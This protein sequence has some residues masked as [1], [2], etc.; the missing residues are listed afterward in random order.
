MASNRSLA[1]FNLSKQPELEE[2]KQVLRELSEQASQLCSSVRDKIN[3]MR[4]LSYIINNFNRKELFF[5]AVYT[6]IGDKSGTITVDT[7]LDLLQ[8]AAAEIEEESEV[9]KIFV[10]L[11]NKTT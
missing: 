5:K 10:R 3:E 8:A 9:S 7:A 1:E 6:F 2:G 4:K 11:F